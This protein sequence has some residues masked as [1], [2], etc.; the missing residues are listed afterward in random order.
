MTRDLVIVEE[1]ATGR[2]RSSTVWLAFADAGPWWKVI[3]DGAAGERLI[4][5]L[6]DRHSL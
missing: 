3:L 6:D 5:L 1:G 2:G 4:K